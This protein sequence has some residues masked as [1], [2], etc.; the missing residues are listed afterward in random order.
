MTRREDIRTTRTGELAA[1]AFYY[2]HGLRF[3]AFE[4]RSPEGH[5]GA[6]NINLVFSGGP[7]LSSLA[8]QF[9]NDNPDV[10]LDQIKAFVA[11]LSRRLRE[12]TRRTRSLAEGGTR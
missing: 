6:L 5:G 4:M 3:S 8:D 10:T 12:D 2:A 9:Y 11:V 1:A 7:E